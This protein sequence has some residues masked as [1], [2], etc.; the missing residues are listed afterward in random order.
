MIKRFNRL[1]LSLGF[2]LEKVN[3]FL[4]QSLA[5][6]NF[7]GGNLLDRIFDTLNFS[8]PGRNNFVGKHLGTSTSNN[9][10]LYTSIFF[11]HYAPARRSLARRLARLRSILWYASSDPAECRN[12]RITVL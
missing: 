7:I 5:P 11:H 3:V 8:L 10:H 1:I 9:E 6:R 12:R 4:E 2:L